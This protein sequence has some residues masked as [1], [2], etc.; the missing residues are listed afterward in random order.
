M[1]ET[2][3]T[4]GMFCYLQHWWSL[5]W[6]LWAALGPTV[7]EGHE[8]PRVCPEEDKQAVKGWQCCLVRSSWALGVGLVCREEA[9][10]WPH[11]SVQLPEEGMWGGRSWVLLPGT[12]QLDAWERFKAVSVRGG[13]DL[14]LGSISLLRGCSNPGTGFLGRWLMPQVCQCWRSIWT[15][16]L[17]WCFNFRSALKWSGDPCWSLP[18]EQ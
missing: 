4:E 2:T 15:M 11:H 14:I 5:T 12:Q 18:A 8:G 10:G 7:G 13:S 1:A 6:A 16:P 3:G 9:E 17:I